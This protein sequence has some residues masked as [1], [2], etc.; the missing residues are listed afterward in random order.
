MCWLLTDCELTWDVRGFGPDS[1]AAFRHTDS[2]DLRRLGKPPSK[3]PTYTL[4][5]AP[6]H[7]EPWHGACGE[8]TLSL[9]WWETLDS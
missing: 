8:A 2:L 4:P 3:C 1:Q 5:R 7:V 6:W 9:L